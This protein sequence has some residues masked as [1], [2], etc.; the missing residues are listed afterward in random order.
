MIEQA[1]LSLSGLEGAKIVRL[2]G[3]EAMNELSEMVVD[4]LFNDPDLDPATLIDQNAIVA[5]GDEAGE[6]THFHLVVLEASHRGHFRGDERYRV[7]LGPPAARLVHSRVSSAQRRRASA[8]PLRHD[9]RAPISPS[10]SGHPNHT[11][12]S[13]CIGR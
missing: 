8:S 3:R 11:D 10:P 1:E 9:L 5:L 6:V 7:K 12:R 2:A 13:H 4:V